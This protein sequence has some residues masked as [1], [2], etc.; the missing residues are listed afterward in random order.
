MAT[1][2]W[3]EKQKA[4]LP[5]CNWQHITFT[6]PHILWPVFKEN[7]Y[8]LNKLAKLAAETVIKT[9]KKKGLKIG[10]FTAL[11]TFGRDLKWNVHIHLSVTMGGLTEDLSKWK[12]IRFSKKVIMPMW[13][14]RIINMLREERKAG[15]I[16]LKNISLDVEYNKYWRVNFSTPTDNP[17]HTISY[18]G[19][20]LKRPPL[21]Q[22]RLEH[23]DG[24]TVTFNFLNHRN[25]KHEDITFE[26][27]EFIERFTQHIPDKG[28]RLI[29]YYG[30]LA[31]CVRGKL[32]PVVYGLIGHEEKPEYSID[33]ATSLKRAFGTDPLECI[34]CGSRMLPT[35]FTFGKS[36]RELMPYHEAIATRQRIAA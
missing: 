23:Y 7:R 15:N 4:I 14:Y 30:F 16:T 10:V 2:R 35:G 20:Y 29:R 12:D 25:K 3:I 18:L 9:A 32:L 6:I 13:R 28:F 5:Q 19:R 27:D 1:D 33:W 36:N 17:W 11:H 22:S 31:N 8:L 21:S 34:L 24:K 26:T